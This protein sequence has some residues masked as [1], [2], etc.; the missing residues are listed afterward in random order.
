DVSPIDDD[1]PFFFYT[2]QS[3]D[4]WKFVRQIQNA[5]DYKVNKAVPLL[6]DLMGVS[7]V[8]TV[9][10]LALPP[11]LLGTRLPVE[12]G[13]RGFLL[14]FVCL[15]AGYIMIQVALIQKFVL[16][17]G[18]PTHALRVVIFSLLLSSGLG[19]FWSR[20]LIGESEARLSGALVAVIALVAAIAAVGSP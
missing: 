1:R 15:G 18:H 19:S 17:L 6:F 10:V 16:F 2:V 12:K 11:L 13:L 7:L 4:V 20:R 8:A 9:I 5:A 14:Y 3:G